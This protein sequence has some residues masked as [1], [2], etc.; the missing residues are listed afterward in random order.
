M[1][2]G[3]LGSMVYVGHLDL[4]KL[5]ERALRRAALPVSYDSGFH[6]LPRIAI[7]KALQLGASSTAEVSRV[8]NVNDVTEIS[9]SPGLGFLTDQILGCRN[10]KEAQL[11]GSAVLCPCETWG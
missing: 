2:Y 3:K 10:F 6:A 7:A 5:F 1:R 11:L 9:R 4:Q 8:L